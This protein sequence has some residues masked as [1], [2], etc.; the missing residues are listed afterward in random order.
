MGSGSS[1]PASGCGYLAVPVSV[2]QQDSSM[3]LGRLQRTEDLEV[4]GRRCAEI[5]TILTCVGNC[6]AAAH[7]TDHSRSLCNCPWLSLMRLISS[8]SS[9]VLSC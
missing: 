2:A 7:D 8:P 9:Q 3:A 6:T 1:I 4:D 5:K